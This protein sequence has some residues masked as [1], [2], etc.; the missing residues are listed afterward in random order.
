MF[1]DPT[2]R[3]PTAVPSCI[4]MA[5]FPFTN[6]SSTVGANSVW[7]EVY[8]YFI[9][10]QKEDYVRIHLGYNGTATGKAWFDDIKIEEVKDIT[11]IIPLETVKWFFPAYKYEDKGWIFMHIEGEP[12]QRGYQHGYLLANEIAAYIEKLAVMAT[13]KDPE[14]GWE[15]TRSLADTLMLR[16]FDKEYLTEMKGIA[17]GAAAAGAKFKNRIIDFID[18]VSLNSV[19]D[20]GQIHSAIKITPHPLSGI[21]FR[22]EEDELNKPE[23]LHKCSGFVATKP[24]TSNGRFVFGQLFMWYGYPGVHFNI[25]LDIQP[26]KGNRFIYETFPGG[27]HSATDIYINSA[28]ITIGETTVFQT[29]FDING[30]PQSNRIRKAAQYSNSVD[31]VVKILTENNNGFYTNDWLIA[32][33]KTD[34]I[35]I[36][37]L[38][39]KKYKLWCSSAREF[40]G[41]TEGFYW[42]NNNAKDDDV[43]KEYIADPN[44]APKDII[45]TPF[46]RDIQ[47]VEF[48]NENKGKIN[49]IAGVNLWASS[50]MNRPHA[51]DGKIT[52]AEMAE[53]LMFLAH[54]GK[55]TLREKI[56]AASGR[57]MSDLPN[58]QPHL[59][60]GYS[61]ANPIYITEKLKEAYAKFN[62]PNKSIDKKYDYDYGNLKDF[63]NYNEKLLWYNTVLPATDSENWF[64]SGSATYWQILKKLPSEPQETITFLKTALSDLNY[65]YLFLTDREGE[66]PPINAH[67][68]Y[69]KYGHYQFP[70]IKGT[71]LLHQIHLLLGNET[72]SK[73]MN[74]IHNQFANKKMITKDFIQ[75]AN[76]ISNKSLNSFIKQWLEQIGL[77]SF[78]A[79]ANIKKSDKQWIA[80]LT[81][82][83]NQP[84]YHLLTTISIETDSKIY[85]KLI[86]IKDEKNV[87]KFTFDN[88]PLKINI[89]PISDIPV[90]LENFYSFSNILDEFYNL[91]IVYGTSRQIEANHT[92]A[93]RYQTIIADAYTE[94]LP[95]IKKDSEL[96]P[97]EASTKDLIILGHTSNNSFLRKISDKIPVKFKHNM[98]IY[99]NKIYAEPDDGIMLA[100]PNPYNKKRIAYII[101][102]NGALQLYKMTN[103]F[104]RGYNYAIFKG[105]KII[106]EGY[107]TFSPI[108]IT[109]STK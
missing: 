83:Q 15:N 33:A 50:P 31:D 16:K 69:D 25:I 5:S 60:L 71:I 61:V 38:G 46:N 47:F 56:P 44:N 86:E 10:T 109:N 12:Y 14:N 6:H 23:E 54:F 53:K 20:L 2:S 104:Y 52:T 90:K 92:I 7:T 19:I 105:E 57:L 79:Q 55:V 63:L 91:L 89:N 77:P 82:T 30:T 8:A 85:Y 32:D 78:N 27:I 17:D 43:R 67:R 94:I 73:L 103:K 66:I 81:I 87:Y 74:E 100:L 108:L 39:T 21:S 98:F 1:S 65:R 75:T 51:C 24:A 22:K 106:E 26:S 34:E 29:P 93:L 28:G 37:L 68:V 96:T 76:K 59:S 70:K 97:Q 42:S 9:A 11:E 102:A 58:A 13:E 48:Y 95:A 64:T 101:I 88:K 36:L 107:N 84:I 99:D 40:P 35:A 72:F 3:Y 62:L 45:F 49:A 41:E 4:T 18:I 80:Y